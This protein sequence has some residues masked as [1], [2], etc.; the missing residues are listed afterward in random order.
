MQHMASLA[1]TMYIV[2][3]L[4]ISLSLQVPSEITFRITVS[5]L[6]DDDESNDRLKAFVSQVQRELVDSSGE[7][8]LTQDNAHSFLHF[9]QL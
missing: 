3:C 4:K 2:L 8:K 6:G 1:F 5:Y 7:L 9:V